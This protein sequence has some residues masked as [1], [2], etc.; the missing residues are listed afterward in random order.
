MS[1]DADVFFHALRSYWT[2]VPPSVADSFLVQTQEFMKL[3]NI[4]RSDPA[5]SRYD[6]EI[7]PELVSLLGVDPT[8]LP[9]SDLRAC[10][11]IF[12]LQVQI[13]ENVFYAINLAEYHAHQLNRGWINL[14]RRWTAKPRFRSIWPG[15][16]ATFSKEF[17]DFAEYHLN[18]ATIIQVN[19]LDDAERAG[20][21]E[22]TKPLVEELRQEWPPHK[23]ERFYQRFITGHPLVVLRVRMADIKLEGVQST[24]IKETLG[25]AVAVRE[26]ETLGDKDVLY[27]MVWVRGAHRRAAIGTALRT[28]LLLR[29][30]I[31]GATHVVA[32]LP[33]ISPNKPGY[34]EELSGWLRF[35]EQGGFVR[36]RDPDKADRLFL[37]RTLS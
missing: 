9:T 16:R 13:M 6:V 22:L 18:L 37:K 14:F 24:G 29:P 26:R 20:W 17:V 11:H 4:L 33:L 23:Y 32:E 15:L 21:V 7:Y 30:E 34:G 5:L 19:C 27:V 10:L 8:S 25:V 2:P 36:S 31:E 28:A 1:N 12:N 3:E 35:Y